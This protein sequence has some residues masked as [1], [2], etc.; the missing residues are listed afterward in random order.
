MFDDE[1]E[2]RKREELADGIRTILDSADDPRVAAKRL[3]F[4]VL[5]DAALLIFSAF[6]ATPIADLKIETYG[7]LAFLAFCIGLGIAFTA[8]RFYQKTSS[9]T[10][11]FDSIDSGVMGGYNYS[12]TQDR[13]WSMWLAS[14][15]GGALNALL[16]AVIIGIFK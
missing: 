13:K 12:S 14:V 1:E 7:Y 11:E 15:C 10:R 9:P 2:K 6:A 5:M 4:L 16:F 3:R 8:F